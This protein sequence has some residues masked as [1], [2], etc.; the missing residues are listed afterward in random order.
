MARRLRARSETDKQRNREIA[1][2]MVDL[3]TKRRAGLPI[4]GA[5]RG[6]APLQNF[7]MCLMV[8]P[9]DPLFKLFEMLA[10]AQA[11]AGGPPPSSIRGPFFRSIMHPCGHHRIATDQDKRVGCRH[12]W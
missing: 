5:Q 3:P 1:E 2:D 4:G 11:H 8:N 7:A 9:S 10:L 12:R 6:E